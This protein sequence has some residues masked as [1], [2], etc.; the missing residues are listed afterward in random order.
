VRGQSPPR[1]AFLRKVLAEGPAEG[2]EPL[3]RWQD[4]RTA[5]KKGEYYLVYFGKERPTEWTVALPAAGLKEPMKLRVE[6]L[7]TWAMTVTPLKRV[8]EAR[9]RDRY[10]YTCPKNPTLRLPGKAYLALRFRRQA[11]VGR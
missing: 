3:D 11:V 1:L 5:G 10:V 8:F 9:L 6:V 2:L 4:E 7:D